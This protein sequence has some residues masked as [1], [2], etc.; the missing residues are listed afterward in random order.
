MLNQ[1]KSPKWVLDGEIQSGFEAISHDGLLAHIPRD[2]V[3]LRKGLKAGFMDHRTRYTTAAGTPQGSIAS[4]VLANLTVDGL[5]GER[6]KRFPKPKSGY[7]AQVNRG[8]YCADGLITARS[9]EVLEQEVKPLVENFLAERGLRWSP[10][11]TVSTQIDEGFDFRGQRV[12]KY[13]G[14]R[15]IKPSRTSTTALLGKVREII[16]GNTPTPAGQLIGQRNPR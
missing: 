4:P 7:N 14:K 3:M 11:K 15:L 8:R 5:E 13:N 10:D 9:K 1:R 16:K 6:R 2:Q 12:R